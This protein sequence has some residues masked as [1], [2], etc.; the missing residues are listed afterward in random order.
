MKKIFFSTVTMV[1]LVISSLIFGSNSPIYTNTDEMAGKYTNELRA[2]M[3][4]VERNIIA[5]YGNDEDISENDYYFREAAQEIYDEWDKELNAVYK[6]LSGKLT[7]KAKQH[8]IQAQR[9]WIQ[10]RDNEGSFRYY[11]G[12]EEGGTLGINPQL[13]TMIRIVKERTLNL[14]YMYDILSD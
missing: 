9:A 2:R 7:G 14:A 6:K 10:Y 11:E 12:N 13:S 3:E 5:K 1:F 8:L 4:R